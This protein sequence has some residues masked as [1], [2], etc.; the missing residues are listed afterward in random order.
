[1][2]T[3]WTMPLYITHCKND[4]VGMSSCVV[5]H[6]H[7]QTKKRGNALLYPKERLKDKIRDAHSQRGSLNS[8]DQQH[9]PN[10]SSSRTRQA[11]QHQP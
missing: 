5:P 9:L 6:T 7:K 3:E 2:Y 8:V 11:Y 10:T 1:M 4:E